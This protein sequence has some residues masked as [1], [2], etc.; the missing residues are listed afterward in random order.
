MIT[1]V[2]KTKFQMPH[3]KYIS[4]IHD[5]ADEF[6]NKES[7]EF[8]DLIEFINIG[9]SHFAVYIE[10][11]YIIHVV[12][13]DANISY[14][15]KLSQWWSNTREGKAVIKVT[16]LKALIDIFILLNSTFEVRFPFNC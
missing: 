12:P 5:S 14:T 10:N 15:A 2:M 16:L 3:L 1:N 4:E 6:L 11:G 8:G 9:Y 7:P 13:K